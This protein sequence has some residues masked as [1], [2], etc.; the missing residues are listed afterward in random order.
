MLRCLYP[1]YLR[2]FILLIGLDTFLSGFIREFQDVRKRLLFCSP[3]V[4]VTRLRMV[5]GVLLPF[6][7]LV[8]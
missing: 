2:L 6:S 8:V 1:V 4:T 3:E 5:M 7:M